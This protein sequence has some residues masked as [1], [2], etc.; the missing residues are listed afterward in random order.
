MKEQ[1]FTFA[2]S[3]E[4]ILMKTKVTIDQRQITI[5]EPRALFGIIPA[6]RKNVAFPLRNIGAVT[7][8]RRLSWSR[9][10]LGL[11]IMAAFLAF[12][13]DVGAFSFLGVGLGLL[14]AM[15][16]VKKGLSIQAGGGRYFLSIPW[17]SLGTLGKIKKCLDESMMYESDKVDLFMFGERMGQMMNQYAQS[18]M[19]KAQ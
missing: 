8:E 18:S 10:G 7:T 4:M 11:L 17:Y 16:G 12:G 6:G 19:M 15:S 3:L 14:Y 5:S 1:K 2:P 13:S 9:I